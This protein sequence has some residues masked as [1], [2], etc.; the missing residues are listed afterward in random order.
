VTCYPQSGQLSH[1]GLNAFLIRLLLK[2]T[3]L[4]ECHIDLKSS[5]STFPKFMTSGSILMQQ[6]VTKPSTVIKAAKK[7]Q[8]HVVFLLADDE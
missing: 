3:Y 5:S 6:G 2:F 7:G 1:M 4:S 8:G